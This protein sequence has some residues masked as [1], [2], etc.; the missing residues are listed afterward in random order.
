MCNYSRKFSQTRKA[1]IGEPLMVRRSS[2]PDEPSYL[3]GN[4]TD[5]GNVVVCLERG[6]ELAFDG[7]VDVMGISFKLEPPKSTLATFTKGDMLHFACGR[8]IH[9]GWLA[10]GQTAKVL[11]LPVE[12]AICEEL[13]RMLSRRKNSLQTTARSPL[14]AGGW[15]LHSNSRR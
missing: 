2:V 12:R 7:P 10:P 15:M 1:I 6:T 14:D 3:V 4:D 13:D 9:V 8:K 11:Q 5:D